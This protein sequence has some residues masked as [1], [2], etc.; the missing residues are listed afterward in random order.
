MS[1]LNQI[2]FSLS[3]RSI[4][5]TGASSGIGRAT[6]VCCSRLGAMLIITG[7]NEERLSE[8]MNLLS[9][10]EHEMVV[11]DLATTD[12]MKTLVDASGTI[13]GLVLCAGRGL[14]LPLTFA[15]REKFDSVFGIDFYSP[16]ELLRLMVKSKKLSKG[17]SVV[18]VSSVGGNRIFNPGGG[19][20]GAAKAALNSS[21]KFWAKELAP[22][23]IRVNSVCPGM[24]ETPLINRGTLTKEQFEA[25]ME[26]YPLKRYGRP[27]DVA[28]GIVYLLSHAASWVTGHSL[29]IDGGVSI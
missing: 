1:N 29:V 13:D 26:K 23:S 25:D 11:A 27:E 20:Y 6:A 9:G 7:R 19:V 17:S 24:V 28:Y 8:T 5:V 4:L 15:T 18:V 3:G 2:P 10:N 12:G 14:T 22:K 21:M 16:Q